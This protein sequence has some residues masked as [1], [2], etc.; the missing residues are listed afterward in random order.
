[1]QNLFEHTAQVLGAQVKPEQQWQGRAVKLLDGSNV[2]MAD[3]AANQKEY[4]QHK[5]QKAGCG[6]PIAKLVVMFSLTTAAAIGVRIAALNTSEITLARSWY[7]SLEPNDVV[8]A[9]RAYGSYMEMLQ[10]QS[11]EMVRKE[12]YVHLMA[13][14]LLRYLMWQAASLAGQV[15]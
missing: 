11:P 8:L 10:T 14:N 15:A 6:F 7:S 4:P 13:Y 5:N 12:I 1:M 3:S 2:V 9:D